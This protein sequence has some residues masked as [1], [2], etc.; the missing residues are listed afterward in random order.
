MF[1]MFSTWQGASLLVL[2]GFS[3]CGC[4][5]GGTAI[6]APATQTTIG[7]YQSLLFSATARRT[8]GPN[9]PVTITL[10]IT[11]TSRQ[12]FEYDYGGCTPDR[13]AV[14][15]HG[16]IV[17]TFDH[18]TPFGGCAANIKHYTLAPELTVT[19][20]QTWD[21]ILSQSAPGRPTAASPGQYQ[22]VSGI[23]DIQSPTA[24]GAAPLTVTLL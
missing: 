20:T 21:R 14:L 7:R 13:A 11:N 12:P 6:Q 8:F 23:P 3:M 19:F 2:V 5:G 4:G 17:G 10:M 22:I 9:D 24:I 1:Q 16:Q 15:Q 18:L